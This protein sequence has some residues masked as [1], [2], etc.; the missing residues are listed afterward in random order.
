MA[1]FEMDAS[2]MMLLANQIETENILANQWASSKHHFKNPFMRSSD[3]FSLFDN[4]NE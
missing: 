3:P 2:K 1:G 4:L